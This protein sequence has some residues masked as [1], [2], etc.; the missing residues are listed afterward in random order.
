MTLRKEMDRF[1]SAFLIASLLWCTV[2]CVCL[3]GTRV[4]VLLHFDI[5]LEHVL[6]FT[7]LA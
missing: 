3:F 4:R 7:V 5:G 1:S 2:M 6:V